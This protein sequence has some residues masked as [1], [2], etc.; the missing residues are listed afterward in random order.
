MLFNET[1]LD[2]KRYVVKYIST[3]QNRMVL[4]IYMY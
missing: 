1:I 2:L 4:C 3:L